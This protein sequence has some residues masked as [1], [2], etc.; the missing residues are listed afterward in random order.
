MN[1]KT[2]LVFVFD[3]YADWEVALAL[4]GLRQSGCYSI[5]TIALEKNPVV[6]MAGMRTIPDLDFLPHVDLKDIDS[7]STAMVLLPG[8]LM[9]TNTKNSKIEIE[10][11]VQHCVDQNIPL[12]AIGDATIGLANQGILDDVP[13][14]SNGL[15]TLKSLAPCYAGEEFYRDYPCVE[16]HSVITASS[17]GNREFAQTIFE[18]LGLDYKVYTPM[19]AVC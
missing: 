15:E 4:T 1:R 18:V 6:S 7:D 3:G 13:H 2:V 9:W 14:A 16:F 8:G 11:L 17:G 12:A 5:K 10:L 19:V